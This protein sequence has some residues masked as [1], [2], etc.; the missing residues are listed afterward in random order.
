MSFL[1]G[2]LTTLNAAFLAPLVRSTEMLVCGAAGFLIFSRLKT[3]VGFWPWVALSTLGILG[4][5]W[6]LRR[7]TL[8]RGHLR[9][10]VIS[11]VLVPGATV[12][13]TLTA[14]EVTAQLSIYQAEHEVLP[15][16]Q[17]YREGNGSFPR[18]LS[19]VW[20][21]GSGRGTFFTPHYRS[22]GNIFILGLSGIGPFEMPLYR[23][24]TGGWERIDAADFFEKPLR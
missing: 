21:E 20:H 6:M 14:V 2:L 4:T 22:D 3:L 12:G 16:L 11:L 24:S 7:G 5:F 18:G 15:K 8:G 9:R 1:R 23:S 19:E 17:E 10:M 13:L